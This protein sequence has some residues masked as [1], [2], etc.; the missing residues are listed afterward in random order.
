MTMTLVSTVQVGAGGAASI[1][2]T[3]IP[4]TGTDLLVV[5][6]S[7]ENVASGT[8]RNINMR[9]NGN[10]SDVYSSRYL[11][12]DGSSASSSTNSGFGFFVW[13]F[14]TEGTNATSSTF[15]N[16]SFYIPNYAGATNKS[17]S[18]DSVNENNA[19]QALQSIQAGLFASTSAISSILI[20]CGTTWLQYSSAS[21]YLVTKGSGGASVS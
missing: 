10:T 12:G 19:T 14:A 4:Q 2:F 13:S 20:Y 15:S 21:L 5:L 6:S 18:L 17:V 8:T 11:Y 7:R 3:G 9:F 1:E 16:N